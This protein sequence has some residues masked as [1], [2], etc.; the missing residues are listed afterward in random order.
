MNRLLVLI[1]AI[2][3]LPAAQSVVAQEPPSFPLAPPAA[4]GPV[5][6]RLGYYLTDV[7][8]I[9][10]GQQR[11]EVEGVLTLGWQDDRLVFDPA[12][13]GVDEKV[14]QGNYQFS[15][16]AT[17][18]WPQVV[19]ANESGGYERQGIIL[20]QRSDGWMT[21][22]EEMS[23]WVEMPME[24]RRFPFDREHFEMVF[25]VLGFGQEDV[26]LQHDS[27]TTGT[28]AR[29]ISI[30]EWSLKGYEVGSREHDR[31]YADGRQLA[32]SAVVVTLDLARHP[33]F[34]L[35][36]VVL[37][38][39][40][41]V[42]LSWSVFWMDRESLGNRMDISFIGILTVVAY[43]I[44]I[45]SSLP[46]IPYFTL[47]SAFI[48]ASF[49]TMSASVLVNLVVD[50]LDRTGKKERGD[51]LDRVC[52]WAFPAGYATLLLFSVAYFF[53]RS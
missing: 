14:F 24:L 27:S 9:D 31:L 1:L 50:R 35:R 52:R 45:G 7:N 36:V 15:E 23:A 48:Y 34:V 51:R 13:E 28:P 38:M 46:R 16:V 44:M 20:H 3:Q 8:T 11:F 10:E 19:L 2:A 4:D 33:G 26:I 53:V 37:P 39:A 41:L 18:W 25:E 42:V 30:S 5:V 21:Y 6:V 22:V 40:L 43:Q 49:F 17:G 29:G 12:V 47:M 32:Q